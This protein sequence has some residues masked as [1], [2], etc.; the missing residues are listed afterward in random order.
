MSES[1]SS[2]VPCVVVALRP[3]VRW[4]LSYYLSEGLKRHAHNLVSPS[5]LQR[6]AAWITCLQT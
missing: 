1:V 3:V 2:T 5:A 6:V 4:S